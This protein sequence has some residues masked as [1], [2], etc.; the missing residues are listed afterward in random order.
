MK[1]S[2]LRVT[3]LAAQGSRHTARSLTVRYTDMKQC[4][5]YILLFIALALVSPSMGHA[6]LKEDTALEVFKKAVATGGHQRCNEP[7]AV[8]DYVPGSGVHIYIMKAMCPSMNRPAD[9]PSETYFEVTFFSDLSGKWRLEGHRVVGLDE[10]MKAKAAR[11]AFESVRREVEQQLLWIV[12]IPFAVVATVLVVWLV[13][14]RRKAKYPTV[15]RRIKVEPSKRKPA[16]DR[17]FDS[18]MPND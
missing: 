4:L 11:P 10:A 12:G 9:P 15:A 13:S 16:Q 3:P 2:D 14:G 17:H 18:I 5:A 6:S 8:D 1:L 7:Y